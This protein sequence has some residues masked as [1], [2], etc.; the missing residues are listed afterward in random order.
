MPRTTIPGLFVLALCTFFSCSTSKTALQVLQPSQIVLPD[1]VKTIAT[2]DRSKPEKGFGNFLEGVFSGEALGQDKEGRERALS[3]I[4]TTLSR[5]PRFNVKSTGIQQQGSRNGNSM[6]PPMD[7]KQVE[8]LCQQY[9]ADALLAIESFDTNTNTL[10]STTQSKTK[11]D[12]VETIKL[13][14]TARRDLRVYVGWRLYDPK[15]RV[16]LDENIISADDEDRGYGSSEEIAKRNLPD[17]L[18]ATRDLSGKVGEKYGMRIAPV[19]ITVNRTFYATSKG[20]QQAEMERANRLVQS[21]DWEGAIE[22]WKSILD[23]RPDAKTAGRVA[24]NLAVGFE[25]LGALPTA[26]EWAQKAFT[27]YGHK[28]AQSY[29]DILKQRISDQDRLNYQLKVK[30]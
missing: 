7:W 30:T 12:G 20:S 23:R 21:D 8:S 15:A 29:I 3:S 28:P 14:Y 10:I 6:A 1:H 18:R 24:H 22:V 19:W 9:N 13:N 27:D 5:T 17:L 25:R 26:L 4:I 2:L 11:K 16:V